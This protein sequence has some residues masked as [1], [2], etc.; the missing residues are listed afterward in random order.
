MDPRDEETLLKMA[1]YLDARGNRVGL[2][3]FVKGAEDPKALATA[4][5]DEQIY[6]FYTREGANAAQEEFRRRFGSSALTD[7]LLGQ[8]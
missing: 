8:T 1:R 5:V 2:F 4:A 7:L 6:E 3:A